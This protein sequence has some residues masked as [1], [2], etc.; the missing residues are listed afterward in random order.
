MGS[1]WHSPQET[2]DWV[3]REGPYVELKLGW[4]DSVSKQKRTPRELRGPD[5]K[6]CGRPVWVGH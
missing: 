2:L 5:D 3:L 1:N 6:N 4:G